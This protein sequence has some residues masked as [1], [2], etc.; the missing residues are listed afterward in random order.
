MPG[1]LVLG[2]L[3]LPIPWARPLPDLY[4]VNK[5]AIRQGCAPLPGESSDESTALAGRRSLLHEIVEV[6]R[7]THKVE[8][9]TPAPILGGLG[10]ETKQPIDPVKVLYRSATPELRAEVVLDQRNR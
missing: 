10:P 2:V 6:V 7:C 8:T 1:W 3:R 4:V 9:I 5:T